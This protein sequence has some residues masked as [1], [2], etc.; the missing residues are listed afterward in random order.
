MDAA[1]IPCFPLGYGSH[2][3]LQCNCFKK[4]N[5]AAHGYRFLKTHL[6]NL[7]VLDVKLAYDLIIRYRALSVKAI[8]LLPTQVGKKGRVGYQEKFL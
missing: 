4:K 8:S 3:S 6:H 1:C 5:S 7:E 2:L